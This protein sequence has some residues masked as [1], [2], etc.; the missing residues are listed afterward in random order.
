MTATETMRRVDEYVREALPLFEPMENDYNGKLC[1]DTFEIMWRAGMLGSERDVPPE[2]L[3]QEVK[4][5]FESPLHDAIEQQKG[6]QF[7]EMKEM[8]LHAAEI[9][10]TAIS[11]IDIRLAFRDALQ[12]LSTPAAWLREQDEANQ[13]AAEMTQARQQMAQM[14][15]AEGAG[16]AMQELAAGA[17][18]VGATQ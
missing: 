7:V 5:V 4:F 14:Q 17:E 8:L 6:S 12:G 2:L 3:E 13:I 16:V 11:D 10:D 18:A 1:E 15:Q 9:D